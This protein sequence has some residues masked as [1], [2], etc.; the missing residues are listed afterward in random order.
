VGCGYVGCLLNQ[1]SAA[2]TVAISSASNAP[3]EKL[4]LRAA[5]VTSVDHQNLAKGLAPSADRTKLVQQ[6]EIPAWS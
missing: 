6:P 1:A 5:E 3:A 4:V 2:L